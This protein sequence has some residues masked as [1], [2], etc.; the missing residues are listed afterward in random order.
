MHVCFTQNEREC[1][2]EVAASPGKALFGKAL[3]CAVSVVKAGHVQ[4]G[5]GTSCVKRLLFGKSICYFLV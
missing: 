3:L 2:S 5:A 4:D 1:G